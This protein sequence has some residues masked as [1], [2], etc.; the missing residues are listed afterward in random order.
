MKKKH[1][2]RWLVHLIF[3][4]MSLIFLIP[5][6]MIFIMSISPEKQISSYGFSFIP[7]AIDFSA[8][9][10]LFSDIGVMGRAILWTIFLALA[11]P[12]V[13][14]GAQAMMAYALNREEKFLLKPICNVLLTIAMMFG[15]GM[16]PTYIIYTQWYHLANNPLVYFFAGSWVSLWDVMLFKTFFKGVSRSLTEAA[17]IDG[18]SEFKVLWSIILPMCKPIIAMQ[19]FTSAIAMWNSWDVSLIYMPRAK[20]F[21][22]IQYY[23]QRIMDNSELL[24][25]ALRAAGIRDT[26]SIPITTM[27]YAMCVFAVLPIL[28]LFPYIQKFFA[29]GIA[30]GSVK[31]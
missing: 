12:V 3:I 17:A 8:Y 4:M 16:I 9:K 13:R 26:S 30:T 6:V 28:C 27:K 7:S 14:I 21:W 1:S 10:Y 5:F 29:K 22:T 23:L 25:A 15:G 24:L 11:V 2:L 18:A 20:E 31:E 19:Y